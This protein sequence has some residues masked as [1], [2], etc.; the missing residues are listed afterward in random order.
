LSLFHHSYD[1]CLRCVI[2]MDLFIWIVRQGKLTFIFGVTYLCFLFSFYTYFLFCDCFFFS[3]ICLS[4][5]GPIFRALRFF[6]TPCFIIF[7]MFFYLILLTCRYIS[8]YLQQIF[9]YC[10]VHCKIGM[11]LLLW[12]EIRL[13]HAALLLIWFSLWLCKSTALIII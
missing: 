9:L 7:G 5:S 4:I 1:L 10:T 6:N 8:W 3:L 11:R 13:H 2:I 12:R